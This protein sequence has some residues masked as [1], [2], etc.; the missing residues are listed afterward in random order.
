MNETK[1]RMKQD[2]MRNDK[3]ENNVIFQ[4]PAAELLSHLAGKWC[5]SMIDDMIIKKKCEKEV[6]ES[7]D[8]RE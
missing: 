4:E 6:E 8:Y 2:L 5:K 7:V 1:K 3:S